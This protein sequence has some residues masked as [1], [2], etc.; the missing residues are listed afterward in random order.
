MTRWISGVLVVL[1][2]ACGGGESAPG[3]LKHT[4]QDMYIA[5][6]PVELKGSVVQTKQE[7]DI[8]Q[9]EQA[10]V[11]SDLAQVKTQ[12]QIAK[13]EDQSADLRIKSA[14][15]EEEAANKSANLNAQEEAKRKLFGAEQQK[16]ATKAKLAWHKADQSYLE[17]LLRFRQHDNYAKEA[18]W[19]LEKARVARNNNIRPSGFDYNQFE[20]QAIQRR[21]AASRSRMEADRL[22][23]EAESKK[24]DWER[25]DMEAKNSGAQF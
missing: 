1:A 22:R 14:K 16:K 23:G 6:V 2:A 20:T 11:E 3:P 5:S 10:K 7:Y 13:N 4:I 21:D 8:A 18:A 15:A 25:A 24:R 9:M 17:K 12:M 19:Q